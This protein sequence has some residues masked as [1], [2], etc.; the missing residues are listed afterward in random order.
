MASSARTGCH[1]KKTCYAINAFIRHALN[2]LIAV[3]NVYFSYQAVKIIA[4][5]YGTNLLTLLF[6]AFNHVGCMTSTT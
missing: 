6:T 3:L 2:F 1:S 4:D 5:F